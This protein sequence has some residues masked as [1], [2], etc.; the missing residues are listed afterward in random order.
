MDLVLR[1]K[2]VL[3]FF[4]WIVILLTLAHLGGLFSTFVLGYDRI[5]GIIPMFALN[6]EQNVPAFYA[7]LTLLFC[8]LLLA[9]IAYGKRK[10]HGAYFYHWAVLAGLFI[11]LSV[12]EGLAIH[13][14]LTRP[15]RSALNTGGYLFYAWVIPYALGLVV[16]GL[17]Y[18]KFFASLPRKTLILF[19]IAFLIFVSGA[20]GME[21]LGG[22]IDWQYGR[23]S[24]PYALVSTIEEVLE[25]S[26]VVIFI[27]ALLAYIT[28]EFDRVRISIS[29]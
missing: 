26:G 3:R 9:I 23:D 29:S 16:L 8:G 14:G 12:D 22:P 25:M 2:Q 17:V 21:L 11:F 15:L 13:E 10:S 7:T 6:R 28:S 4:I 20:I 24:P 5:F 19:G 1:P 18:F 27:Y